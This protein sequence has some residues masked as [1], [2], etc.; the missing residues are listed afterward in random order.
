MT[1]HYYVYIMTN[2]KNTVLYPGVTNDL[3]VRAYQHRNRVSDGFTKTYH[4]TKLV[5][6]EVFDDVRVAIAYEKKIKGGSRAKK[7]ALIENMNPTWKDLY[8]SVF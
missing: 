1:R 3:A 4:A 6:F 8:D 7:I 5:W 2:V